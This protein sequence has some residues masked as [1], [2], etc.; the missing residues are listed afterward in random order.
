MNPAGLTAFVTFVAASVVS[1][2][3]TV[4]AFLPV[5]Q[6]EHLPVAIAFG[7]ETP[8]LFGVPAACLVFTWV[9]SGFAGQVR[10]LQVIVSTGAFLATA[11]L[12][13]LLAVSVLAAGM[14]H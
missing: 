6:S 12:A 8:T 1:A 3:L 2:G 11:A 13:V 10:W 4:V 7:D 9:V 5:T 14:D